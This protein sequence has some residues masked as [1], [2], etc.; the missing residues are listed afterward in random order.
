MK[1]LVLIPF[2]SVL[3][4]VVASCS[5]SDDSKS[6][7]TPIAEFIKFKCNGTQ[8]EFSNPEILRSN[9]ITL[10]AVTNN[11]KNITIFLPLNS[12]SGTY[13]ISDAFSNGASTASLAI[14]ALGLDGYAKPDSGVVTVSSAVGN[15]LKGT[16]NF[17]VF[18]TGQTFVISEGSFNVGN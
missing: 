6:A 4:L 1:K 9:E 15:N 13:P 16:F 10:K 17:A 11:E 3:F 2:F 8:Y 5:K 18:S 7:D 14:Y 12:A